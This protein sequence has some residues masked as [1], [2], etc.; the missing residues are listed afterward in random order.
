MH[1][2]HS[3]Q[4][5]PPRRYPPHAAG[6]GPSCQ[7]KS[8][9]RRV[10]QMSSV[11]SYRCHPYCRTNVICTPLSQAC[12]PPKIL[13]SESR[14]R[15]TLLRQE[16]IEAYGKEVSHHSFGPPGP[17]KILRAARD[18]LSVEGKK[19]PRCIKHTSQ[20][21]LNLT[22]YLHPSRL[23]PKIPGPREEAIDHPVRARTCYGAS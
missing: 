21:R 12:N 5:T 15:A 16:Y 18:E 20:V 1:R 6:D 11:L 17:K 22:V 7:A 19:M 13:C 3:V 10:V 2:P 8:M 9:S 4:Q 23:Q 14:R